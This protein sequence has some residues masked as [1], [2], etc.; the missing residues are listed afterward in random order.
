MKDGG[1]N[2]VFYNIWLKP[3]RRLPNQAFALPIGD[4]AG[5]TGVPGV[6]N[7]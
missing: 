1:G 3:I 6:T 2:H 5:A 4:G 7:L